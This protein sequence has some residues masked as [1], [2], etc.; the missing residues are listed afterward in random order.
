MTEATPTVEQVKA[1]L[2]KGS[3]STAA[4]AKKATAKKAAA[5]KPKA[6][7]KAKAA[8]KTKAPKTTFATEAACLAAMKKNDKEYKAYQTTGRGKDNPNR[9]GYSEYKTAYS[10]LLGFRKARGAGRRTKAEA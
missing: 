7:P 4:K 9:K 10:A 5:P 6:A 2:H 1:T 8:P 3:T